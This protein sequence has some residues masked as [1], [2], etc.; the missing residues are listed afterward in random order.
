MTVY[1]KLAET[2]AGFVTPISI[3]LR[4]RRFANGA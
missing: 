3:R 2:F 1:N 4:L